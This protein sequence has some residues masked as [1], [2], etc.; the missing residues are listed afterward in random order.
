M[1][2]RDVL[3]GAGSALTLGLGRTVA[4]SPGSTEAQCEPELSID[5]WVTEA[6]AAYPACRD[7]AAAYLRRALT[8]T[9]HEVS[10]AFGADPQRFSVGQDAVERRAWPARVLAGVVGQSDVDPVADVNLLLTDGSVAGRSAG[11][12]VPHV[13]TV[14]GARF[15][16]EMPPPDADGED[17]A[18]VDYDV[19]A[20]VTHLVLHE[21]G[22]ALGLDHDHGSVVV[23]DSTVTVSPMVSGYA[24]APGAIRR[25]HLDSSQCGRDPPTDL[26]ATRRLSMRYASC[27]RRA[28][29]SYARRRRGTIRGIG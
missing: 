7:T 24:W 23:V 18:V 17:N 2:R 19:P 11:Y 3:V 16:A 26:P 28:L 20:A 14:P 9:G 8:P 13:A 27:A 21:V 1:R 22:H 4:F 15:L 10:I 6:A 25:D 5:I 12:A 29:R